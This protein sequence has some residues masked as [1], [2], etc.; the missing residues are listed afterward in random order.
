MPGQITTGAGWVNDP[1]C[2]DTVGGKLG[3]S[4]D[5]FL[6]GSKIFLRRMEQC[7]ET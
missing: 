4:Y 2:D 5:L 7:C 6:P 1:P 3:R